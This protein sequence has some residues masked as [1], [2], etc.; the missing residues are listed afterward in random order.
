LQAAAAAAADDRT[1]SAAAEAAAAAAVSD[2]TAE[3]GRLQAEL[4]AIDEARSAVVLQV[5]SGVCLARAGAIRACC[6][7]AQ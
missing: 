4:K 7:N 5:R 3:V 2:L 1:S 6:L